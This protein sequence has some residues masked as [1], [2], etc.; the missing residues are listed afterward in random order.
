MELG[1]L[2]FVDST[3]W[4]SAPLGSSS[5]EILIVFVQPTMVALIAKTR[6]RGCDMS[7]ILPTPN[8]SGEIRVDGTPSEL[9]AAR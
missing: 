8:L 6:K 5:I 2:G 7:A 9:A 1:M 3:R 4:I